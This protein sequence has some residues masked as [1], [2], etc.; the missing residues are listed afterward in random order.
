MAPE[1][2]VSNERAKKWLLY[3]WVI[4]QYGFAFVLSGYYMIKS[5]KAA[6]KKTEEANKVQKVESHSLI[7]ADENIEEEAPV[8][9]YFHPTNAMI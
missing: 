3:F 9:R 1:H 7:Q 2:I 6:A 5:H 8:A 4:L